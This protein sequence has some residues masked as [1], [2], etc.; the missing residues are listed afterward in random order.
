MSH[1][2]TKRTNIDFGWALPSIDPDGGTYSASPDSLARIKGP[3]F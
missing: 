3:Y 1:F 2:N